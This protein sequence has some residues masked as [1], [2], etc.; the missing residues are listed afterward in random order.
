MKR[1]VI[2]PLI[3][4]MIILTICLVLWAWIYVRERQMQVAKI[5]AYCRDMKVDVSLSGYNIQAGENPYL[6]TEVDYAKFDSIYVNVL[7]FGY[8]KNIDEEIDQIL[9]Q[10]CNTNKSDIPRGFEVFWYELNN[11]YS[12]AG[13]IERKMPYGILDRGIAD[14]VKLV[15]I[16]ND[17]H[18]TVHCFEFDAVT[19]SANK[20]R[21]KKVTEKDIKEIVNIILRDNTTDVL[22]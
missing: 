8:N 5:Q 6:K 10:M 9:K 7:G 15:I 16:E 4:L 2:L 14:N 20:W 17:T 13:L 3:V 18:T 21:Y 19:N 1:K 11:E 22:Q 12:V